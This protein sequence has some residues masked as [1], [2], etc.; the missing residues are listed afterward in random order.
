MRRKAVISGVN[1]SSLSLVCLF[2]DILLLQAP[3]PYSG[4][5]LLLLHL[6]LWTWGILPEPEFHIC[7]LWSPPLP[8]LSSGHSHHHLLLQVTSVLFLDTSGQFSDRSLLRDSSLK[9][10]IHNHNHLLQPGE[11]GFHLF[12]TILDFISGWLRAQ[13]PLLGFLRWLAKRGLVHRH[14]CHGLLSFHNVRLRFIRQPS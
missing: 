10:C 8:P 7:P 1:N 4:S 12:M 11:I 13:L 14:C 6:L 2:L 5:L 3:K 9:L